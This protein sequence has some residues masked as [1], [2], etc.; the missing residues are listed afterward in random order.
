MSTVSEFLT[1]RRAELDALRPAQDSLNILVYG[2]SGTGKTHLLSTARQPVYIMSFDPGGTKLHCLQDMARKGQAVLDT[3]YEKEDM[4]KPSAFKAFE[5]NINAMD[6]AKVW[7]S[8]GTLA[9]DSFSMLSEVS[10][11]YVVQKEGR[12]GQGAQLQDYKLQQHLMQQVLRQCCNLP[13][14]F[15]LTGHIDTMRD[16][17]T[18]RIITS[19][20]TYGKNAIKVPILF[21]EVLLTSVDVKDGK[22]VYNV[23]L[24]GDAKYKASTRAFAGP[25]FSQFETPDI[26]ALRQKA[27]RA[28]KHL[29]P[30][31][32]SK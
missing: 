2:D 13:C 16:E 5:T 14:D 22:P 19:L 1:S 29:D 31:G 23:R 8:I 21:D 9:I 6:K 20:L 12:A 3:T 4:T 24:I 15:I 7:D 11:N 26:M 30:I 28:V 25:S 17:V 18:G 27:G 10:M 32:E